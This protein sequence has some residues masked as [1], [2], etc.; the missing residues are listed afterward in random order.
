MKKNPAEWYMEN[1]STLLS[2]AEGPFPV[3]VVKMDKTVRDEY[4]EARHKEILDA[5]NREHDIIAVAG[6]DA[7]RAVLTSGGSV[8]AFDIAADAELQPVSEWKDIV[9]IAVSGS[10]LLGWDRKETQFAACGKSRRKE[11]GRAGSHTAERREDGTAAAAGDNSQ[12]QCEVTRWKDI[13]AV[14]TGPGYTVGIKQDGFVIRTDFG[15]TKTLPW[16]LFRR[17]EYERYEELRRRYPPAFRKLAALCSE[18]NAG[19]MFQ[20]YQWFWD[21]IPED[22]SGDDFFRRAAATWL[23]RA[24]FY[25]NPEAECLLRAHPSYKECSILPE[26]MLIPGK[27]CVRIRG[28]VLQDLGFLDITC[29]E[30]IVLRG[31]TKEGWYYFETWA[32]CEGPDADGF[33]REEE[34][35]YHI[36]DEFL[37]QVQTY[38][39]CT[40]KEFDRIRQSWKQKKEE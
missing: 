19:A 40:R 36:L 3:S 22:A 26:E 20:M 29:R 6:S 2:C 32:G 27:G 4:L 28:T 37:N 34:Y 24:A 11:R 39:N 5:W 15:R 18:G 31:R 21:Q 23:V 16:K 12:G 9:R 14:R 38:C 30:E 13:A 8:R 10:L 35:H 1:L 33:G 7:I 17:Y 25:G